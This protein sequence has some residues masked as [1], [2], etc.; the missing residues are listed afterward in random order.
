VLCV[1][2]LAVSMSSH[3]SEP[4]AGFGVNLQTSIN[5]F[6]LGGKHG[7]VALDR[8]QDSGAHFIKLAVDWEEIAPDHPKPGFDPTNPE[9]PG[10]YWEP[11]DSMLTRAVAM[12]LTPV[13]DFSK[14]PAW[15]E[16]PPGSGQNKPD[17]TQ[18]ALFARAFATHYDGSH[19]GLP[20]VRYWEA[21]NEPNVSFFLEPQI[22]G[23]EIVSVNAYR[24]ILNEFSSAIHGVHADNIVIGGE[25][26]PNEIHR[27]E[28]TAIGPLEFTR[29]LFCLSP[30][31]T[32]RRVCDT[33]VNVD[34]WSVH[35]Y[36]SGGPSTP[37]ANPNN[38]WIYNLGALTSLV[39]A[40]QQAGTLVS[41]SPAQVWVS[42]FAWDSNPPNPN[43]VPVT[44]E[45]RW[46][47]ESLYRS[48]RAGISVFT[49]FTLHDEPST[50]PPLSA[51]LYFSCSAN[52]LCQTPKPAYASF[53][54]PFVAF[55]SGVARALIWGR[56]P[57]GTTGAVRVQWRL[58]SAWRTLAVLKTDTNGI[59]TATL[60]LPS[61]ANP[62]NAL[63][64]AEVSGGPTSPSFSLHHPPDIKVKPFG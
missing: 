50:S 27:P 49:W 7:A 48:W 46:V 40:A 9:D 44:L 28:V 3:T 33:A 36:T 57:G 55:R 53:R 19:R 10:Y 35:P 60:P 22:Q 20:R 32:P 13:I 8:I 11:L 14:P 30:G 31:P 18:L 2:A 25:L 5:V 64:R 56:T 63:L 39:R 4:A 52:A 61:R 12:G 62:T 34:V 23:G 29:R 42:E 54:F 43:A 47:A 6:P 17:P 24:T 58:G 38:V 16:S 15:A 26:F 41:S 1:V 51:G 45:H 59:F 21:W 37:P